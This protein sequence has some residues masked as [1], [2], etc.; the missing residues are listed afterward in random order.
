MGLRSTTEILNDLNIATEKYTEAVTQVVTYDN[1]ISSRL[2]KKS[3]G[4]DGGKFIS[5]PLEYGEENVK[6]MSEYEEIT[7]TPKE[8]LD[9]ARFNWKWING[10]VVLSEK[11][12]HIENAGKAKLLELAEIKYKNLARTFKKEFSD[13]LFNSSTGANDFD[14]LYNICAVTNTA[15]SVGGITPANA[16]TAGFDWKPKVLDLETEAP[17][18][19]DL[20]NPNSQYYIEKIFQRM[21]GALTIGKDAP[22]LFVTTQ[23]VWD[24]YETALRADKRF[25]G[26]Y[27]D[28]DGGFKM[29]HFRGIPIVVDNHVPGGSSNSGSYSMLYALNENYLGFRHRSGYNFKSE[30]WKRTE[31]QHVYFSEMNWWGGFVVSRRDMQGAIKGLP[32]SYDSLSFE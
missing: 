6:S 2:L 28:A 15:T 4:V 32:A 12:M 31:K 23:V 1:I 27:K 19:D 21:T 25:E 29:L 5:I 30:A 3:K 10:T 11:K 26:N 14:S 9:E 24:A 13:M 17:T 18:F 8:I 16:T 7:L 22:T 20:C